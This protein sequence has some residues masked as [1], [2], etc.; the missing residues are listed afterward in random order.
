MTR[1]G[2]LALWR[3]ACRG[4]Q[5]SARSSLPDNREAAYRENNRGVAELE[6]YAYDKAV[7]SFRRA[8]ALGRSRRASARQ[9]PDRACTTP[10]NLEDADRALDAADAER[11]PTRRRSLTCAVSSRGR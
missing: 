10:S 8:I 1:I 3:R 2:V 11:A 9:S 4:V 7:E 5:Q 6:Q